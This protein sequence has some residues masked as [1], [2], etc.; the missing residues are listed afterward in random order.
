MKIFSLCKEECPLVSSLKNLNNFSEKILFL[1]YL[2]SRKQDT[3]KYCGIFEFK[4]LKK[5]LKFI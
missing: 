5:L 1:F 3:K 4:C 2:L